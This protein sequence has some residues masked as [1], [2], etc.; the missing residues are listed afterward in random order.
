MWTATFVFACALDVLGRSADTFPPVRLIDH[1]PRGVSQFAQGYALPDT[2]EIVLITSTDA[3]KQAQA[4][5][6]KDREA[7]REIASVLVH[8]EW[9]LRHGS[10]EAGA[11]DAQLMALLTTGANLDGRLFHK[12]K[13]AKLAVLAS[14][15]RTRLADVTTRQRPPDDPRDPGPAVASLSARR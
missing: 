5:R 9:H 8:E 10:D 2:G 12:I 15:K 11:Y 3:F 1:P 13:Q 4:D 6:C 14:A 7:I